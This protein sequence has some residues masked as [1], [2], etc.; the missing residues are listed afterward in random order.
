MQN[1]YFIPA[2]IAVCVICS[3]G[4]MIMDKIYTVAQVT[5]ASAFYTASVQVPTIANTSFEMI[6]VLVIAVIASVIIGLF[7]G[8][9]F[10]GRA[11]GV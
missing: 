5:S 10:G 8:G 4:V 3:V 1:S 6:L 9:A 7:L 11:G 2:K